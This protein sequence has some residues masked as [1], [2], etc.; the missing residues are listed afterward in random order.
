MSR[1]PLFHL[2]DGS[3]VYHGDVLH[4]APAYL[5]RAG[6]TCRAEFRGEGD[7]VVIRSIPAGAVPR[8]PI[9]ALL[10]EPHPDT[11]DRAHIV[12]S[13]RDLRSGDIS[14]R[15]LRMFRLGRKDAGGPAPEPAPAMLPPMLSGKGVI[16]VE[17]PGEPG[18]HHT[19]IIGTT[20]TGRS[21]FLEQEAARRGIP[22]EDLQRQ[23]EPTDEQK[24]SQ[25]EHADARAHREAVRLAAVREAYWTYSDRQ[26]FDSL[27]DA[28]I[29]YCDVPAPTTEQMKRAFAMLPEEVIG[30]GI[31]WGFDDTEVRDAVYSYVRD[32]AADVMLVISSVKSPA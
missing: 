17:L 32:N 26:E 22:L 14:G 9:S 11:V 23:L 7:S 10:R 3:P 20:G 15:D 30:S 25:R 31:R 16:S 5:S 13:L 4:V 21:V 27:H 1:E 2:T 18:V 12:G 24:I 19:L 8:V 28:L 6:A 29:N